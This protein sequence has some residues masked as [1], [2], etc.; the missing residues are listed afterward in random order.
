MAVFSQRN[1]TCDELFSN[2]ATFRCFQL[3]NG[4]KEQFSCKCGLPGP[5]QTQ[6]LDGQ[7]SNS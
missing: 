4:D 5:D 6:Q 2:A 1:G 7:M 3:K